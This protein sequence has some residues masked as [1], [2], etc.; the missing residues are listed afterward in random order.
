MKLRELRMFRSLHRQPRSLQDLEIAEWTAKQRLVKDF[1]HFN[2]GGEQK[3]ARIV[4]ATIGPSEGLGLL[5]A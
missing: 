4:A 3:P 5:A 2:L 1:E